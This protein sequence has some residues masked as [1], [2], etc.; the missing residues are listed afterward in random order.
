MVRVCAHGNSGSATFCNFSQTQVQIL[1]IGVSVDLHRFIEP[2][3]L[4]KD[5][6]PI[7]AQAGT[8][9]VN[10]TAGVSENLDVGI[11]NGGEITVS[12]VFLAAQ[13]GMKRTEDKIFGSEPAVVPNRD[14]PEGPVPA[15]R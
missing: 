9:I 3:R 2:G 11:T 6:F 1:P 15:L 4:A 5:R 10:P 14:A 12:L 7:R 13:C 8:I